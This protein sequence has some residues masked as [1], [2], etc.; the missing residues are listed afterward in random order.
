MKSMHKDGSVSLAGP[1]GNIKD[2]GSVG[3]KG[4]RL[5]EFGVMCGKDAEGNG[6]WHTVAAWN[7]LAD[8]ARTLAKG[9]A[10]HVDGRLN[11]REY[12]GKTYT[13]VN[14]EYIGICRPQAEQATGPQ[15]ADT[16]HGFTEID[17]DELPF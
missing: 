2:K 14:A 13:T 15:S 1:V 4:S 5:V 12:E 10:V 17:D 16:Q 8:V 7:V 3:E 9:D 6:I 11:T